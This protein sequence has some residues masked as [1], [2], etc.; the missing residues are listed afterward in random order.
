MVFLFLPKNQRPPSATT[1]FIIQ[2]SKRDKE[3]ELPFDSLLLNIM[4]GFF[5]AASLLKVKAMQ[6]M[7]NTLRYG[8]QLKAALV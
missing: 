5:K 7:N 3:L 1:Q 6:P 2:N 4:T 8:S